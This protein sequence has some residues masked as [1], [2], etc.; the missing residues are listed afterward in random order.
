MPYQ[1]Q[2]QTRRGTKVQTLRGELTPCGL[3]YQL[4]DQLLAGRQVTCRPCL[5]M[6]KAE[7]LAAME[8]T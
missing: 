5:R 3:R 8:G 6:I 2:L 4:G 7:E 1:L